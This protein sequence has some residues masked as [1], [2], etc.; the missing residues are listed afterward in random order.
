VRAE[1]IEDSPEIADAEFS[2]IRYLEP[3]PRQVKRFHNAFRLQL[4][5]ANEN[6]PP[7]FDFTAAELVALAKWVVIR[8]R[9]PD[10]GEAIAQDPALLGALER[11]VN[12]E[13]SP[14][15][16]EVEPDED[17]DKWLA[18][19]AIRAV[20]TEPDA[21]RRVSTLELKTFLRVA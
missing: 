14:P 4:Y 20:L 1:R 11:V 16:T 2:A 19:P 5:V 8:L 3:N 7:D 6:D 12:D 10:L 9:W 21:N 15:G 17:H 18:H 13:Q